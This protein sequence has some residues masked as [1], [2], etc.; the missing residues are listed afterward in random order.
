[1]TFCSFPTARRPARCP[2]RGGGFAAAAALLL[3]AGAWAN[4]RDWAGYY[5]RLGAVL[6][7][8]DY[9]AASQAL[10]LIPPFA[11]PL[12]LLHSL[13]QQPGARR[14]VLRFGSRAGYWRGCCRSAAAQAL[15]FSAALVA[16]SALPGL[17]AAEPVNWQRPGSLFALTSGRPLARPPGLPE[18]WGALWA[19]AFLQ[20]LALLL[21]QGL[22]AS[23]LRPL[24]GLLAVLAL[25]LALCSPVRPVFWLRASCGEACWARP[26]GP[27][28][29]LGVWLAGCA[30]L[31]L[32][33]MRAWRR[34]D[35]L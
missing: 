30:G 13:L 10:S 28:P 22:L 32:L 20:L 14:G 23:R 8:A 15:L 16:G 29:L 6:C 3:A 26:G 27:L 34:V 25:D 5:A 18:V 11:G 24:A 2:W 21:L 4:S 33:G 35:L 12:A 17:G 19:A 9:A 7:A 1:M 31:Y